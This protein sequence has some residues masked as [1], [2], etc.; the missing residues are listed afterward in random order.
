MLNSTRLVRF[1]EVIACKTFI[2]SVIVLRTNWINRQQYTG[3]NSNFQVNLFIFSA[4]KDPI[5]AFITIDL[6][7]YDRCCHFALRSLNCHAEISENLSF[8]KQRD[9][10]SCLRRANV[11]S[12]QKYCAS[13]RPA[14]IEKRTKKRE[15][16]RARERIK[17]IIDR[18]SDRGM[19]DAMRLKCR[20]TRREERRFIK[21]R[22]MRHILFEKKRKKTLTDTTIKSI[23]NSILLFSPSS[24]SLHCFLVSRF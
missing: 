15:R 17:I 22:F 4:T 14:R 12:M 2:C 20:P 9:Y 7:F 23:S 8:S 21:H 16:E 10:N 6:D 1:G 19:F 13:N 11:A 5:S 18:W 24:Y 3:T